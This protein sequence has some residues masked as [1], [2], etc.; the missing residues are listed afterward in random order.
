MSRLHPFDRCAWCG[1]PHRGE[2]KP[3]RHK[4]TGAAALICRDPVEC[5]RRQARAKHGM[6]LAA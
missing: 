3:T 5:V 1:N 4:D 2:L 6:G